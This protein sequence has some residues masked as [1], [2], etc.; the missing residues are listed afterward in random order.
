[1][2][3]ITLRFKISLE[4]FAEITFIGQ[5]TQEAIDKLIAHLELMKD[6]FP[7]ALPELEKKEEAGHE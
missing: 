7:A 5:V 2:E 1:M 3:T 6:C 4:C